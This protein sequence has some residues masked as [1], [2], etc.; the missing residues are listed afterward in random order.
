MLQRSDAPLREPPPVPDE[1]IR[2]VREKDWSQT[3]LGPY[4]RWPERL[5]C[6]VEAM[7]RQPLPAIVLWGPRLIQIYNDGY[8][9]IAGGK[10]P[11]ALGQPTLECWREVADEVAPLYDR[12]LRGESFT[13]ED[14]PLTIM[15]SEVA[16]EAFISPSYS[17]LFDDDGSIAGILAI[18][19]ETTDR[20][21]AERERARVERE[22][23]RMSEQRRLALETARMGWWHFD[24]RSG[25]V[26]WDERLR[27]IFGI[28]QEDLEYPSVISRIHPD[29]REGVHR[30]VQRALD[31]ANTV[32]YAVEYRVLRPDGSLRW[33]Q[34]RG[35]VQ[36]RG[37]GSQKTAIA[38]FGTA[39]DITESK[40]SETLLR[41]T[42]DRLNLALAAAKLGIWEWDAE[43][44]LMTL[45]PRAAEI[46]GVQPGR[47]STRTRL[48][49]L[50]HPDYRELARMASQ[51][52]SETRS[53]YD[54]EY[55]LHRPPGGEFWIAAKGRG[56][57]SPDGRLIG[58]L[59]V[60]QD[61]TDRK[62]A[63]RRQEALLDKIDSERARLNAAFQH[64]PAF[65]CLLKGP[66]HV[67]EYVNDQYELLIGGRNIL[68]RPIREA[69]PELAGQ[70]YFEKLDEVFRSGERYVG[71]D[72][73]VAIQ[74]NSNQPAEDRIVDFVYQPIVDS[75]G[76]VTAIFVHGVDNTDFKRGLE[77]RERLLDSERAARSEAERANKM[78]DE[79]LSTLSHEL[80]TPLNAIVGWAQ[81][82]RMGT[83]LTSEM[84]EG[85]ETIERNALAQA[86]IIEDLLDMSRII[87]GKVR[88]DVQR[89]D[90]ADVVKAGIETVRPAAEG[91]GVR[92][93][94][95]VDPVAGPVM[96]DPNR[97]HQV[98][99]NLL[100]NAVK[101]TPKG[102][103]VQVTLERVNSHLEV[104]VVDTGMGITAEFLPFVFDR[105]RQADSSTTRRHGGLGLGLAIVKQLVELHGGTVR[106]ASRGTGEG[107][108]FTVTLPLSV[109]HSDPPMAVDRY[110]PRA[111]KISDPEHDALVF[112]PGVRVLVVDD[113]PDARSL[114]KKILEDCEATV[115]TAASAAEALE[116]LPKEKFDVLVSD[117]GMPDMDGYRLIRR[118]RK[119]PPGAGANIP[120]LA[121]TAFARSEDR[122][123]AIRYGFN[124][125]IVKPVER[126][127]LVTM[128]ASLA[129]AMRK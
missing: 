72:S 107:S 55:P 2:L 82:L 15:R 99:W 81:L 29:D 112:L 97:L 110:H 90:L 124:M 31:P 3:P 14:L 59:G 13:V 60:V 27:G 98:V 16:E 116:L 7:L 123:R 45:S 36:F 6:V 17:P 32:P 62:Q 22:R 12:V 95:A 38:F 88:L 41:Q 40:E 20:V 57:Y 64:S 9:L 56:T 76:E 37:E 105:F 51:R 33:V 108:R 91:K 103:R 8:R 121:L 65:M 96:G 114:V 66:E 43:S 49:D 109:V 111:Q 74:R 53:D 25:K 71:K 84:A 80:R 1:M 34:S 79:F 92:L 101:F 10:H 54:I 11:R 68:G 100:T 48:R 102:G 119:L 129:G 86:R 70:R 67:F 126:A 50:L 63:E 24:V 115:V 5:R 39:L 75:R 26:F 85:L 58:M 73:V 104:S 118:V 21:R 89:V 52:A 113:E 94:V 83:G 117:I 93:S 127:E 23:V 44:D 46:Y 4:E 30:A 87:S 128:V 120:A 28:A 47:H 106:V 35:T 19:F 42:A 61:I 125:H 77:E 122:M 69:L 78:K 18:V